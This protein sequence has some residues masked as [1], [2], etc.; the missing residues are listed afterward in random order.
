M[1]CNAEPQQGI[2][3]ITGEVLRINGARL[4]VKQSDGEEVILRID[5]STQ[6]GVHIAPGSRIEAKINELN[7]RNTWCR[8]TRPDNTVAHYAS[9]AWEHIHRDT[10]YIAYL[11]TVPLLHTSQSNSLERRLKPPCQTALQPAQCN[12]TPSLRALR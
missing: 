3:T 8:L 1:K 5:L 2:R 10:S 12:F 4:L 11:T 9:L 7:A 6:M